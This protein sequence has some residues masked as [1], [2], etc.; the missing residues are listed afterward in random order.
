MDSE[1]G[2]QPIAVFECPHEIRSI[3]F[4][5]DAKRLACI[6][7]DFGSSSS[8]NLSVWDMKTRSSLFRITA[9]TDHFST[10]CVSFSPYGDVIASASSD[11]DKTVRFW[12][13]T[14]GESIGQIHHQGGGALLAV[15]YSSDGKLVYVADGVGVLS[16]WE[17]NGGL[18][19]ITR[20]IQTLDTTKVVRVSFDTS[21]ANINVLPRRELGNSASA[22]SSSI[23]HRPP[24]IPLTAWVNLLSA[25]GLTWTRIY[26]G[27][28]DGCEI[29]V[30]VVETR[31]M[32]QY[33][34]GFHSP[35]V[36]GFGGLGIS[37]SWTQ[38]RKSQ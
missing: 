33:Y 7:V 26:C 8:S 29:G 24:C 2:E 5:P 9:D 6:H 3:M 22:N 11:L 21:T 34:F 16:M 10:G 17:L 27:G 14:T 30:S 35:I 19:P 15:E 31:M 4:S 1:V 23:S 12:N 32:T 13:G 25:I 28:M 38:A 20:E 37:P 18:T 36:A